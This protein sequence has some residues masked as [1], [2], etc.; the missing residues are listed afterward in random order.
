MEYLTI[1]GYE[2]GENGPTGKGF[3]TFTAQLNPASISIKYG[4]GYG[5]SSEPVDGKIIP[6]KK[7]KGC[8]PQTISLELI[9]DSTGVLPK[10]NKDETNKPL[11]IQEQIELFKTTCYYFVGS[12]HET[13]Y[14]RIYWNQ[15]SLFKY[16]K[17]AFF[18]RV[19]NFDVTYTMFSAT[20][21][22]IRAKINAS[23][24]GTM[25]PVTE[26]NLKDKQSPDLTHM[27]T[28]RAGD[29]LPMLCKK[30]YG[31]RQMHHEV[32]RV[33]NLISF[34]YIEPGTELIFPPIK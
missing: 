31:D 1:D 16:N 21:K 15:E 4:V 27:I 12:K 9:L 26:A 5:G 6:N 14:V 29:T 23:F 30:V 34:R 19:D 8:E 11:D 13:P 17:Q 32:A 28:V 3:S 7:Y 22:P 20:G 10:T 18:A 33:N 2:A 25:D 24:S